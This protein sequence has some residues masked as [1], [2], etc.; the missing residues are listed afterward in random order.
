MR[1]K[2]HF[3]NPEENS[4]GQ[5]QTVT[6]APKQP[7]TWKAPRS[8]IPEAEIF[9]KQIEKDLFSDVQRK[10]VQTNLSKEERKALQQCRLLLNNPDTTDVI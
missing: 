6:D 1:K 2:I 10:N 4:E 7:S 3:Y 8:N 5:Q 9:L